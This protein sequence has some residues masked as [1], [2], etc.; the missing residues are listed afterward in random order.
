MNLGSHFN[1]LDG[2]AAGIAAGAMYGAYGRALKARELLLQLVLLDTE[3]SDSISMLAANGVEVDAPIARIFS[4][5]EG[6]AIR[7]M[8]NN[9]ASL[10]SV[11]AL[12]SCPHGGA[13][14]N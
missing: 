1:G 6:G 9:V 13:H 2:P 5:D 3:A 11:N 4:S 14:G 7:S 10:V 12:A 8:L